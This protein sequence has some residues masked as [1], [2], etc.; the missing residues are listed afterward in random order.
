[1]DNV[2]GSFPTNQSI[3][4]RLKNI[5]S[6]LVG[7]FYG[8]FVTIVTK[9]KHI[10]SR[11]DSTQS[12]S[13]PVWVP[14]EV[15]KV[16]TTS[17][18]QTGN[19]PFQDRISASHVT[20]PDSSG[21]LTLELCGSPANKPLPELKGVELREIWVNDFGVVVKDTRN[22]F[23]DIVRQIS[24]QLQA[25]QHNSKA[26]SNLCCQGNFDDQKFSRLAKK[27][28]VDLSSIE[29][30]GD[31]SAQQKIQMLH[32]INS[33][34]IAKAKNS[35]SEIGTCLKL[36][37]NLSSKY[38]EFSASLIHSYPENGTE[39]ASAEHIKV[40]QRAVLE[41]DK[42]LTAITSSKIGDQIAENAKTQ[43]KLSCI[44]EKIQD[45]T[46]LLLLRT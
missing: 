20:T 8:K 40:M 23:G 29:N 3:W 45:L 38:H 10:F 11:D 28:K 7:W 15:R 32:D 19:E 16:S 14:L 12:A 46:R 9:L 25:G 26:I 36:L 35:L 39:Q 41:F 2:T 22:I 30:L 18:A 21:H 24:G 43:S 1:M 5:P 17:D 44:R 33:V 37:T 31:M 13:Q 34:E 27:L 4:D 6:Q 42:T